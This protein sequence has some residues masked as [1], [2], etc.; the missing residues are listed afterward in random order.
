M[1][2][3]D[4]IDCHDFIIL[5]KQQ[6]TCGL[7][8]AMALM[9]M[10]SCTIYI[11]YFCFSFHYIVAMHLITKLTSYQSLINKVTDLHLGQWSPLLLIVQPQLV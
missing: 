2:I 8:N 7:H 3:E 4:I 6:N 9:L 11:R 10:V 5:I 1:Y